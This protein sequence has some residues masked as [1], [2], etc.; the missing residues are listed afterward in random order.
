MKRKLLYLLLAIASAAQGATPDAGPAFA[1]DLQ[2]LRQQSRAARVAAEV[3][4]RY[5]YKSM[6]IGRAHV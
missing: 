3:L 6:Q 1:P 5:H 2:P 4:T